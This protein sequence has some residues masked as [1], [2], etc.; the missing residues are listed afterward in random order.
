MMLFLLAISALL[1]LSCASDSEDDLIEISEELDDSE[2][3][4][5]TYSGNVKAIIDGSC[6]GCHGSPPTNGAPFSLT[7]FDQVSARATAILNAMSRSTGSP[8]AMPPSGKLPESTIDVIDQWI[9][10]GTKE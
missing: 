6:I 10:D 9:K 7:N 3:G 5:V 8:A 1:Q 2:S 4:V